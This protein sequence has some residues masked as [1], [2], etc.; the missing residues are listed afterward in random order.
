[1]KASSF[2]TTVCALL[3]LI[4]MTMPAF[5]QQPTQP[6]TRASLATIVSGATTTGNKAAVRGLNVNKTYEFVG[7]TTAGTGTAVIGIQGSNLQ[8]SWTTI[9]TTSL[10][11]SATP[12]SATAAGTDRW[13]WLRAVVTTLTGTGAAV[14]ITAGY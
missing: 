8:T 13:V 5:A 14:S 9:A 10:S 4:V 11:L 3:M 12:T 6:G 7:S 1:M 2:Y